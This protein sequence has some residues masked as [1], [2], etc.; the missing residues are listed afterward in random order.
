M[1][2]KAEYK[3]PMY[4]LESKRLLNQLRDF[5]QPERHD[6]QGGHEHKHVKVGHKLWELG[7]LELTDVSCKG[8]EVLG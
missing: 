8:V 1:L 3:G 6:V 5:V 7:V 2:A 4:S